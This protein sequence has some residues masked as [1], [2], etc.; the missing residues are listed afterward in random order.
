MAWSPD[1]RLLVTASMDAT[2]R[3]WD[4]P[5]AMLIDW[6]A[7][8]SPVISLAFSPVGDFLATVHAGEK[9]I[10]LW[11]CNPSIS[12]T[13]V[14]LLMLGWGMRRSNEMYFSKVLLRPVSSSPVLSQLPSVIS[15]EG[16]EAD[17]DT[18]AVESKDRDQMEMEVLSVDAG[19]FP[20]KQLKQGLVTMGQGNVQWQVSSRTAK[21][22]LSSDGTHRF[23]FS[24]ICPT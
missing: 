20:Q 13:V 10:F 17:K 18:L 22:C 12:L 9:G 7:V 23:L 4:V 14:V 19:K 2:M 11:Y 5:G 3:V 21:P 16:D 8:A 6:F 1:A 15:E 24:R